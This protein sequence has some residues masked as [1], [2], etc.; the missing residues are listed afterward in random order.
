M[1]LAQ[2]QPTQPLS[3][4]RTHQPTFNWASL[5]V[6][7]GFQS[8]NGTSGPCREAP[9]SLQWATGA[10]SIQYTQSASSSQGK[11]LNIKVLLWDPWPTRA[12]TELHIFTRPPQVDRYKRRISNVIL[13]GEAIQCVD[14]GGG[15]GGGGGD[16]GSVFLPYFTTILPYHQLSQYQGHIVQ[17]RLQGLRYTYTVGDSD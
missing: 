6:G 5:V 12:H 14:R 2:C 1:T 8:G 3:Y 7:A 15:G 13:M 16:T 9:G 11:Y 10:H 17:G 4:L